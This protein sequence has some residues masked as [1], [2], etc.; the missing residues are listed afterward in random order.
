MCKL[1]SYLGSSRPI[2]SVLS[3]VNALNGYPK[4]KLELYGAIES[5]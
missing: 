2:K 5:I 4:N 1:T 3:S